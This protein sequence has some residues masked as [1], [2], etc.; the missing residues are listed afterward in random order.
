[1]QIKAIDRCKHF[2]IV[3]G[4]WISCGTSAIMKW[5]MNK[6]SDEVFIPYSFLVSAV[7]RPTKMISVPTKKKKITIN[8]SVVMWWIHFMRLFTPRMNYGA[9]LRLDESK[10][11]IWFPTKINISNN[12][13]MFPAHVFWPTHMDVLYSSQSASQPAT[14]IFS[15]HSFLISCR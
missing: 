8:E 11:F 14:I 13:S 15:L 1:M 2:Y 9:G 3:L 6:T 7:R 10:K 12:A 4:V 5:Q